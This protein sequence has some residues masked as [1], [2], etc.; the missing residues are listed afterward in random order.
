MT[1][2][3]IILIVVGVV[4]TLF[5]LVLIFVGIIVGVAFYS[6]GNSEAA[7]SART[8]LKGN[9]KLKSDIG[10]VNDFGSFVTGSVNV[11]NDSGHATIKLKA[12]G[13]KKTVNASVDLV[14]VHG[15][16]WRVTAAS[17]VNESGQTITLLDP[18]DTKKQI[19]T[20]R[21]LAAA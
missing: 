21:F 17:Y 3:K 9:E 11:E 5:I 6:I 19:P 14:F 15:G 20:P 18:Y 2:R 13:A 16:A 1:N 4:A 8:F 12:V 7:N 10:E